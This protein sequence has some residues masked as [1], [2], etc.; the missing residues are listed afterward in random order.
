MKG[1]RREI[2]AADPYVGVIYRTGGRTKRRHGRDR[3]RSRGVW[4]NPT[5]VS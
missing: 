2:E 5:V 1:E 4:S 3:G